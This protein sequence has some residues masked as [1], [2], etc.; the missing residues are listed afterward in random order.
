MPEITIEQDSGQY[1]NTIYTTDRYGF[2]PAFSFEFY[3]VHSKDDGSGTSS[4]MNQFRIDLT[5][6][7]RY[8]CEFLDH[9]FSYR[10]ENEITFLATPKSPD[11]ALNTSHPTGIYYGCAVLIFLDKLDSEDQ[12]VFEKLGIDLFRMIETLNI[13]QRWQKFTGATPLLEFFSDIY[14]AH[15]EGNKEIIFLRTLEMLVFVSKNNLC[16]FT[17]PIKNIFFSTKH[18]KIVKK[19][20]KY[21]TL[22]YEDD[23]SFELI[24]QKYDI[25]Y[26]LFNQIFKTIYGNSPYQYL[27]R[28][29]INLAAKKLLETDLSILDIASQ[30]GYDNPS[31]FSSAFKSITGLLPLTF[32]K[33]KIGME[34]LK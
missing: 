30:V 5:K 25:G 4:G 20:H 17:Q 9:T 6:T 34:H 29:R 19:I 23:I 21:I 16:G 14:S 11:W 24:V 15:A 3:Q 7:G 12:L 2:S 1:D 27:K 10:A 33:E 8:E 32:R 26:S 22:N 18:V 28:I 31:K 13:N